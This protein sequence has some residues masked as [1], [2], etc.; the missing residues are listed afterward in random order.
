MPTRIALVGANYGATLASGFADLENAKLV[1]IADPDPKTLAQAAESLGVDKTFE[2]LDELLQT[3]ELDALIVASPTY[4]HERHVGA[5]FDLGLHVLCASPVGVRGS[6]VSHIVT[7]AGLVGKIFMWANPLRFDPRVSIAQGLVEAGQVGEPTNG[8]A[9][10]LVADWEFP[11]DSWRLERDLGGG[12]LLEVGTQTLDALWFAMGAPDPIEALG[13]RYDTFSAPFASDLEH[14][15]EDTFCGVVRFKNGAS[16][17]IEA[18]LKAALPA[19]ESQQVIGF[20]A[21]RGSIDV[22]A[23]QRRDQD[24]TSY[25]YAKSSCSSSQLRALAVS[26]LQAIETGEEPAANGK[27]ALAFHKMIDALL[28]S[29]REKEAVSIKVERTLDDLFGGL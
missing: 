10:I 20:T 19:G 21:T 18:Q 9:S 23:G 24:G 17:Q 6:E 11:A 15:A 27:Q 8:K 25:D 1:A 5:A 28:T 4:L 26:F 22:S 12:A 14:P 13:S 16:L 7:S 29:S 2:S 3:V